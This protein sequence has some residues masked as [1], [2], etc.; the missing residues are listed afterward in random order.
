MKSILTIDLKKDYRLKI[1]NKDQIQ[2]SFFKEIYLQAAE[3]AANVAIWTKNYLTPDKD[4][5][6]KSDFQ[7]E[8]KEYNNVI[9]FV[10]ERGTGKSSAMITFAQRL[11]CGEDTWFDNEPREKEIIKNLNTFQYAT[12]HTIDP[13]R[14]EASQNILEVIIAELFQKFQQK[15]KTTS[16]RKEDQERRDVLKA[17]Q[18]VYRDLKIVYNPNKDKF[19]GD[20]LETLASLAEGTNLEDHLQKLVNVYLR[21]IHPDRSDKKSILIIPIDDFDLNVDHVMLMTEQVRKYL[22]IPQVLILMAVNIEQ[23]ND[24]KTQDVINDFK[25]LLAHKEETTFESPRDVASRYLLKLIPFERRIIIPTI[26]EKRNFAKLKLINGSDESKNEN[27]IIR[28]E[29]KTFEKSIFDFIYQKTNLYFH[30][31]PEEFHLFLPHSLREFLS[32]CK[33][34]GAF[35]GVENI[36]PNDKLTNLELF[37]NY[38]L[39]TWTKHYILIPFRKMIL[40][41]SSIPYKEWNKYFITSVVEILSKENKYKEDW[42]DTTKKFFIQEDEIQA[43]INRK[44]FAANVSLGDLIYFISF[45][46]RIYTNDIEIKK[47]IFSLN[48][49]YSIKLNSIYYSEIIDNYEEVKFKN[50]IVNEETRIDKF[51]GITDIVNGTI[52]NKETKIIRDGKDSESRIQFRLEINEFYKKLDKEKSINNKDKGEAFQFLYKNIFIK[53]EY[54]EKNYRI[55]E[56]SIIRKDDTKKSGSPTFNLF[57]FVHTD[58]NNIFPIPYNNLEIWHYI[59]ENVDKDDPRVEDISNNKCV[60]NLFYHIYNMLPEKQMKSDFVK[61]PLIRLF[62]DNPK[63][64]KLE[65]DSSLLKDPIWINCIYNARKQ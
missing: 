50:K 61:H 1:E 24:V 42:E 35:K 44:N 21:Y 28:D 55:N 30:S 12:L 16:E 26:K 49:W 36:K 5:E 6:I 57:S 23:L 2:E 48:C 54:D 43:I 58:P 11:I 15:L 34:L 63:M 4:S 18:D 41:S 60:L 37:E 22:M 45:L 31:E 56:D 25:V 20:P 53:K 59:L 32:L 38:F 14:F 10:G 29:N 8:E 52:L 17:F 9:A 13:T 51:K 40:E 62:I 39:Y 7:R 33:L 3:Q 19:E 46:N 47:L 65:W 27:I 64:R